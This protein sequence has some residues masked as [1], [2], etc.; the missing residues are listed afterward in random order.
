MIS[1]AAPVTRRARLLGR[2]LPPRSPHDGQKGTQIPPSRDRTPDAPVK[3]DEK[4]T[5]EYIAMAMEALGGD[6]G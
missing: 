4:K 3:K 5:K 6:K 1:Q 2:H